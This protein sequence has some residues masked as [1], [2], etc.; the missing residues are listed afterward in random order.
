MR[1]K[2]GGGIRKSIVVAP[3]NG[4]GRAVELSET[5]DVISANEIA[6]CVNWRDDPRLRAAALRRASNVTKKNSYLH[7]FP[8]VVFSSGQGQCKRCI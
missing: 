1:I 8:S 2:G 6:N 3:L 5:R 4:R 7:S